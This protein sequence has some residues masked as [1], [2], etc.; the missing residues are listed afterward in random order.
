MIRKIIRF[1][2]RRKR[3]LYSKIPLTDFILSLKTKLKLN[4]EGKKLKKRYGKDSIR[5]QRK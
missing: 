1:F 4:K 5:K 3:I 2:L